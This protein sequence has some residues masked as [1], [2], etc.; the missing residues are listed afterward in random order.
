AQNLGR[1]LNESLKLLGHWK[2]GEEVY[3]NECA[4]LPGF[5]TSFINQQANAKK[6]SYE[7]FVKAVVFKWYC[8]ALMA[9]LDSKEY[10][11]VRNALHVLT[12]IIEV[13]PGMRK[14]CEHLERKAPEKGEM[15]RSGGD[16]GK[17][18]E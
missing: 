18:G 16:L 17:D 5:S 3:R 1:F 13:F 2:S 8:K 11:E 7:D 4:K 6:A 12:R 14:L 10:M 9:C 15:G